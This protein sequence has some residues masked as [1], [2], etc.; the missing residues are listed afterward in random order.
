MSVLLQVAFIQMVI[1]LFVKLSLQIK[2]MKLI[3][4]VAGYEDLGR[5]G[6]ALLKPTKI[7]AKPV[8]AIHEEAGYSRHG[9]CYRW[10]FL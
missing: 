2:G 3:Q 6:K 9:T 4:Y 8:L 7:Y 10:R 5:I 1:H